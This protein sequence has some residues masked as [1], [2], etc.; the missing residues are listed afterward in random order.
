M[1]IAADFVRW[2]A[3]VALS[4]LLGSASGCGR[5][6]GV[7]GADGPASGPTTTQADGGGP[8]STGPATQ[9]FAEAKSGTRL[10]HP[11]DW[12][13][14]PSTDFALRLSPAGVDPSDAALT[15]D[16]PDLPAHVPGWIPIGLVRNGYADDVREAHPGATVADLPPPTVNGANVRLV[17]AAW[18]DS[19][20]PVSEL[21][22]VVVH[23]D[24][25]VLLRGTARPPQADAMRQTFDAVVRSLRWRD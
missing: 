5:T 16:V 6:A 11:A 7:H 1:A 20:G 3:A 12:V 17:K 25:V 4:A 24:H 21:T 22:L 14:R 2:G 10:T 9:T 13:V 19:R 18:A 8:P 23:G 15:L